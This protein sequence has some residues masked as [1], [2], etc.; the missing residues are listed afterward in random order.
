M[1]L[2]AIFLPKKLRGNK[3]IRSSPPHI[4]V[5]SAMAVAPDRTCRPEEKLFPDFAIQQTCRSFRNRWL[6][7]QKQK[8]S[9]LA[10]PSLLL[11]EI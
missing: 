4:F 7:I 8:L 5:T 11:A 9:Y 10:A 3:I 6:F 2:R 1:L